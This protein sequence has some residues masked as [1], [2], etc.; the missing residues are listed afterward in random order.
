MTRD[1]LVKS[2]VDDYRKN[3]KQ[4]AIKLFDASIKRFEIGQYGIKAI[5][6]EFRQ[7]L[8]IPLTGDKTQ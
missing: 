5:I 2:L 3:G 6:I 7:A 4:S 1:Q 8:G